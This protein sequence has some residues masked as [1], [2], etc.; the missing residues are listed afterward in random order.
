MRQERRNR[1]ATANAPTAIKKKVAANTAASFGLMAR[2]QRKGD[3]DLFALGSI[4]ISRHAASSPKATFIKAMLP[5]S[6]NA[7]VFSGR[8]RIAQ[9]HIDDRAL[10]MTIIQNIG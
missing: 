5:T 3:A 6:S 9:V 2:S 1:I 7:K 4:C 10:N 8:A